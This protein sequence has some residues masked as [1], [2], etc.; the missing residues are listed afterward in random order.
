MYSKKSKQTGK[1]SIYKLLDW[2]AQNKDKLNWYEICK[3]PYALDILED[4]DEYID[5]AGLAANKDTRALDMILKYEHKIEWNNDTKLKQFLE[6]IADMNNEKAMQWLL[7]KCQQK[8]LSTKHF[9]LADNFRFIIIENLFATNDYKK[10][11]TT[12]FS[13]I[14]SVSNLFLSLLI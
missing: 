13:V 6:N 10:L 1:G 14:N 3:Q 5:V 8:V 7:T 11:P 2:I 12:Q 4:Y 9:M